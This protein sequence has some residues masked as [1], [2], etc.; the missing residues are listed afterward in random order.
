L[1]NRGNPCIFI[2]YPE[3]HTSNVIKFYIPKTYATL[4]SRNVYW[5]NKC[6]GEFYKV[7]PT[8]YPCEIPKAHRN[9]AD[10][11]YDIPDRKDPPSNAVARA[12]IPHF[13]TFQP[14]EPKDQPPLNFDNDH[15]SIQPDTSP[16]ADSDP[17][18]I[19]TATTP[20]VP[21]F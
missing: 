11:T 19:D 9:M 12:M 21:Y 2:G 15:V 6:Y 14:P 8:A 5:L 18:T 17:E 10:V 16:P 20:D 13:N 4:L 3:D 7:K 1:E